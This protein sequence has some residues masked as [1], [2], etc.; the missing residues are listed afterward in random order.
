MH[1]LS[2]IIPVLLLKITIVGAPFFKTQE[3]TKNNLSCCSECLPH[4]W[5]LF[6]M[7]IFFGRDKPH[8]WKDFPG[9]LH[10]LLRQICFLLCH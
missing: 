2:I 7:L 8:F 10:D 5:F 9:F 1:H 3:R 6:F 4:S